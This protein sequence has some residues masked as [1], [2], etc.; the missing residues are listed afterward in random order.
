MAKWTADEL[1]RI[2]ATDELQL[3]AAGHDGTLRMPVTIWVVRHG[4]DLYVRS[5][6]GPE[7]AWFRT[8]HDSRHG[9]IRAGSI[10][11]NVT[12]TDAD[13]ALDDEIDAEY[14]EKY[15]RYAASIIAEVTSS[16]ARA[17]TMRLLPRG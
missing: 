12:F 3:A 8:A 6:N 5:V 16:K 15:Q 14:A 13:H 9:R 17:T 7:A 11:Q 4:R 2:A 1:A 10:D